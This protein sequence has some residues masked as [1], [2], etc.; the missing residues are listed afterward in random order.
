MKDVVELFLQYVQYDTTSQEDSETYPSTPNQLTLLTLLKEQLSALGLEAKM[1]EYGYVTATLPTN[2]TGPTPAV[3]L[4]AHVDTSP[5]VSGKD[6]HARI[7]P[8]AGGDVPLGEGYVL[9]PSRYPH[10][11]DYVGQHLIVTDGST[12]LGADDKAG[13]AE[14]MATVQYLLQHPEVPRPT[15]K[16]A[17]TPDE[18]VGMGVAHFD[19]ASF[20]ADFGYTIDGGKL[21]EI[22]YECF[23]AAQAR[24][25][26]VGKSIHPGDAYGK[27]VNAVDVFCEFHMALPES[28]RP[29]TTRG[30]EGFFMVDE[31]VGNVDEA[32]A[33]YI[34]RDHDSAKLQEKKERVLRI[35][36]AL[37]AKY[38]YQAVQVELRDQY[39]NMAFALQDN[40]K[41][42]ENAK[43][44]FALAGVEPF[45]QPIRGGTDGA[46]LTQRGLP[47]FN[48]STGGHNFH[49]RYEYIPVESMQKMVDVLV[50]LVQLWVK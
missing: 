27:M 34:L 46:S 8:Y 47:C 1:D 37:N 22:N 20:G 2:Q 24:V 21:G 28:E 29:A 39:A 9:S 7:V 44:A 30:Y 16:V 42:V 40:P 19:V 36:D 14:I 11:L 50:N 17:F 15:I 35:A 45:V 5:A 43:K 3:C 49:G 13:V 41:L 48:L 23:N 12:L 4:I 25:H 38:G 18:E 31:M 6:I 32:D 33:K 26:V 10:M